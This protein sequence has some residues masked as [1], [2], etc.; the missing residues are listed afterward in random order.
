MNVQRNGYI[1]FVASHVP[2]Y[3]RELVLHTVYKKSPGQRLRPIHWR[4]VDMAQ[5]NYNLSSNIRQ[6]FPN[7]FMSLLSKTR[8][9]RQSK[10]TP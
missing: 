10:Y 2:G 3:T 9:R 4:E 1:L 5:F 7:H 8:K 6:D